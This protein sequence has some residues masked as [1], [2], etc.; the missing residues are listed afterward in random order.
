[1]AP[2]ARDRTAR[3]VQRMDPAHAGVK[4]PGPRGAAPS[5][6]LSPVAV[7]ALA[8]QRTAGNQAVARMVA[9]RKVKAGQGL[10]GIVGGS[11]FQAELR[12]RVEATPKL[13]EGIPEPEKIQEAGQDAVA[14]AEVLKVVQGRP[15]LAAVAER[16]LSGPVDAPSRAEAP[17]AAPTSISGKIGAFFSRLK[18]ALT[19]S[20]VTKAQVGNAT[21]TVAKGGYAT[22]TT[23]ASVLGQAGHLAGG[24][25]TIGQNTASAV[26]AASPAV[27][28]IAHIVPVIGIFLAPMTMCLNGFQAGKA[29]DRAARL[30]ELIQKA[31]GTARAAG[32]PPE[33]VTAVRGAMEQKYEQASRKA[34]MAVA[35]ALSLTGGL[36]LLTVALASNPVGWVIGAALAVLGGVY[37][38]YIS[39]RAI[40]RKFKKVDKGVKRKA[41]T[42]ALVKGLKDGDPLAVQAVRELGLNPETIVAKGGDALLFARLTTG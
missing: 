3:R 13:G 17:Q 32:H 26:V 28:A 40:Y 22:A 18:R 12:K 31:D 5:P 19:P 14:D 7:S 30:E 16:T 2:T 4:G 1:M 25:A 21:E 9:Q 36:I 35:S 42:D 20:A 34:K 8:L 41:I 23:G 6:H 39:A 33:I 37:G 27:A 10:S 24:L 15:S 29:W 38:F 11:A